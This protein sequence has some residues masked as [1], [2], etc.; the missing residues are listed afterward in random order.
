MLTG[1][2]VVTKDGKILREYDGVYFE[3]GQGD[4]VE[5]Y[6]RTSKKVPVKKEDGTE[7]KG[8]R[9][10][11]IT[12]A[13]PADLLSE[14]INFVRDRIKWFYSPTSDTYKVLYDEQGNLKEE[15][16]NMPYAALLECASTGYDQMVR[17]EIQGKERKGSPEDINKKRAAFIKM[18]QDTLGKTEKQAIKMWEVALAAGDDEEEEAA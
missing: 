1:K 15:Y 8:T 16:A 7:W 12:K 17:N 6:G 14:A 10:V 5:T 13:N 3:Y 18:A 2:S 9:P 11:G 4:T